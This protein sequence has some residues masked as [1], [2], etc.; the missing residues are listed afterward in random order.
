MFSHP[1][2]S[3]LA[4]VLLLAVDAVV[5]SAALAAHCRERGRSEGKWGEMGGGEQK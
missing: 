3:R 2:V 5:V 1:A 4:P